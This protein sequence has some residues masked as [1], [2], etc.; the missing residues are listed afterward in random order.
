[1]TVS[2][3]IPRP[4][5]ERTV[6]LP[7]GR[8][9]RFDRYGAEAGPAVLALHGTPG[10]RLKF[11]TTQACASDLGL[12]VIAPDR[13]GYGGTDAPPCPSLQAYA[14][15]IARLADAL[16]LARFAVLG[17]S[18]GGPYATA[19]ASR[20]PDRVV[21]LGLV[22]PVGPIA[23]LAKPP[24]MTLLHRLCFGP[25]G[26]SSVVIGGAF[27]GLRLLLRLSPRLGMFMAMLNVPPADRAVLAH[28]GVRQRLA[29]TFTEGLTHGAAGPVI[30]LQIFT[31]GWDLDFDAARMPARMWLGSEDRNVPLAAAHGLAAQ[32][33]NC[34]VEIINDAGHLWVALHYDDVLSWFADT[35]T[36]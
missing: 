31:R 21:A 36:G 10:S 9:I 34:T 25:L 22:A 1:M 35:M 30:D 29:A 27:S 16:D 11:A 17:V 4:V 13:W 28:D 7:D 26:R 3:S 20:L 33:S 14:D 5:A 12:S 24:P 6:Q 8:A 2:T 23:G 15:D 32:L 19:V 18:G